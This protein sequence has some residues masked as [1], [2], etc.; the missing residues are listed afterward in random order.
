MDVTD[1]D[2]QRIAASIGEAF[3]ILCMRVGGTSKAE[4]NVRLGFEAILRHLGTPPLRLLAHGA[5]LRYRRGAATEAEL[6]H[7]LRALESCRSIF[8]RYQPA[9]TAA[10]QRIYRLVCATRDFAAEEIEA[11]KR[12]PE[13][14]L[15]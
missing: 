1:L 12:V 4:A 6:R 2:R 5:P 7:I 14:A 9:L 10:E 8:D 3:A 15:A 13:M 11:R